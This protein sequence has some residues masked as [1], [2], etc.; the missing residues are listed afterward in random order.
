MR[1]SEHST[2]EHPHIRAASSVDDSTQTMVADCSQRWGTSNA[3]P[4]AESDAGTLS[5]PLAFHGLLTGP[6][7]QESGQECSAAGPIRREA[8]GPHLVIAAAA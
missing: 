6:T 2:A 4:P 7:G 1:S 3:N 8:G 5:V